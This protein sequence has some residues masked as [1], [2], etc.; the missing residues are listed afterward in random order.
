MGK[1][2]EFEM[3]LLRRLAKEYARANKRRKSEILYEYVEL[4]G[5]NRATAQKRFRR[6]LLRDTVSPKKTPRG[7]KK[8]YKTSHIEIIKLCWEY[9][10]CPC[11][12]RLHPVLSV[13]IEQLLK[14]GLLT[15]YSQA[16]VQ[17][18][19]VVSLGTL[20]RIIKGFEKP[21]FKKNH[22]GNSFIH[23]QVPIEAD[24]GRNALGYYI[25]IL[26]MTVVF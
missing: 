26:T 7:R 13:T 23:A 20:K 25:I 14:E 8:I 11:A 22:R 16:T 19:K 24:F 2:K 6:F 4:T 10:L 18:T 9:L 1:D 12:E 17:Q 3:E 15:P 21:P 5:V